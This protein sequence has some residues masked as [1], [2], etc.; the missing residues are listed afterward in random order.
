M[1]KLMLF[2]FL[3]FS[4]TGI[5]ADNGKT[6]AAAAEILFELDMEN[7]SYK[8]IRNGVVD[9]TFGNTVTDQQ[10]DDTVSAL[11]NHPDITSVIPGKSAGNFCAVP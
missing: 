4:A 1:R 6:A 7:A 2:V 3:M 8:I 10:F 11:D 5:F 9:I